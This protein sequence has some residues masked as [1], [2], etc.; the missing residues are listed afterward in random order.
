MLDADG[1]G[2]T[3]GRGALTRAFTGT[4]GTVESL[5]RHVGRPPE[6]IEPAF[7]KW[8]EG[9]A[10]SRR[11]DLAFV[12]LQKEAA[13]RHV[14]GDWPG[15]VSTLVRSLE[16]RP[17]DAQTLFNLASAR[18]RTKEYAKAEQDLRKLIAQEA[19]ARDSMFLVFGHYQLGRVHDL[20]GHREMALAE[21]RRVLEL[22]DQKD[23]HRL[24]REAI[25][26]PV[27]EEQLQ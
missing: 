14:A 4:E 17:R 16:L 26:V 2:G 22:P 24:A 25:A 13:Q 21:Y 10:A 8:V 7:R 20:Q 12:N 6:Q 5:A 27:T 9:R 18:M 1:G 11:Q 3:L 19:G 23:V 15:L